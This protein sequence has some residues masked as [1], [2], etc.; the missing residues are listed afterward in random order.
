MIEHKGYIGHF[1]F[2]EK[3]NSFQGHVANTHD[4][5]TYAKKSIMQN[6]GRYPA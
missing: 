5:I 1:F 2:D 4:V 6:K 3:T